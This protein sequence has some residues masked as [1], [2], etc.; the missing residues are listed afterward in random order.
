VVKLRSITGNQLLNLSPIFRAAL[1]APKNVG[2][3]GEGVIAVSSDHG[4]IVANPNRTAEDET[5]ITGSQ[6]LGLSPVFR[7]ALVALKDV[8]RSSIRV[9]GKRANHHR[10]TG[11]PY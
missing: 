10:I 6:F 3:S 1:V 8:G 4:G 7:S 2:S 11:D 5:S 9:F